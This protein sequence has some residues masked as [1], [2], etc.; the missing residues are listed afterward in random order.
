MFR[1]CISHQIVVIQPGIWWN[2]RLFIWRRRREQN[3]VNISMTNK[4][5]GDWTSQIKV[6]LRWFESVK[7]AVSWM[8]SVLWDTESSNYSTHPVVPADLGGSGSAKSVVSNKLKPSVIWSKKPFSGKATICSCQNPKSLFHQNIASVFPS[9]LVRPSPWYV[10]F[11]SSCSS[12]LPA[13]FLLIW[14]LLD[15]NNTLSANTDCCSQI[16]PL[17]QMQPCQLL[18]GESKLISRFFFLWISKISNKHQLPLCHDLMFPRFICLSSINPR[19]LLSFK[20][21]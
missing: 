1:K 5:R 15:F 6:L 18:T 11:R 2:R 7:A 21:V 13:G 4:I 12:S 10:W 14:Y 9:L 16:G 19:G 3:D 17:A 20:H 8:T